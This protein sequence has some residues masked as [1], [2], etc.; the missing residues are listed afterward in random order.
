MQ[1]VPDIE[2]MASLLSARDGRADNAFQQALLADI[3]PD[4]QGSTVEE[5]QIVSRIIG[6]AETPEALREFT[7]CRHKLGDYIYWFLLGTLWVSYTGHSDLNLW[8]RLFSSERPLRETSLM[9]PTE[10]RFLQQL[11][12]EFSILRAH[13][14]GEEDWIAYTLQDSIAARFAC[15]RGVP[16]VKEYRVRRE[17]VLAL[18]LRRGEFEV[19]VLDKT[20]PVFVRTIR[21]IITA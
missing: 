21:A 2:L 6:L 7:R 8:K 10:L 11:P 19:L 18:F 12:E 9:K 16:E 1:Q 14:P 4:F 13:R 3:S 5:R 20:K 17:D 15:E